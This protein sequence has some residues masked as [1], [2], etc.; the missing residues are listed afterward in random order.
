MN[1]T[2][3]QKANLKKLLVQNEH[4]C[5]EFTGTKLKK[6][7]GIFGIGSRKDNTRSRKLAHRV[8]YFI[9]YGAIPDGMFVCHKCDNPSCCNPDHLF[10]G[11]P[12]DN[13]QDMIGKSRN[14]TISL[15]GE[16]NPNA[17]FS[18]EDVIEISSGV[19]SFNEAKS[20]YGISKSHFYRL[21]SGNSWKHITAENAA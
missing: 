17:K 1:V 5:L 10:L 15:K 14:V 11:T 9:A 13:V 8:A 20:R 2:E 7:Y 21:R 18:N 12:K 16:E 19:L 3:K 6:G 4:G